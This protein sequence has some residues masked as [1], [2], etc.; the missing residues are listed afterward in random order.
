[1]G[2]LQATV[3]TLADAVADT[4]D[5]QAALVGSAGGDVAGCPAADNTGCNDYPAVLANA[6]IHG[7]QSNPVIH[8][9]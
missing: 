9:M 3:A 8:S 4:A 2:S 6:V 5:C 1:V 7:E